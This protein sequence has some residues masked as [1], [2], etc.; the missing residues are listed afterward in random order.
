MADPHPDDLER[1]RRRAYSRH[2][3]EADLRRLAELQQTVTALSTHPG[4][5][6]LPRDADTGIAA[7]TDAGTALPAERTPADAP[8]ADVPPAEAP[9]S[10]FPWLRPAMLG[11]FAGAVVGALVVI[12]LVPALAPSAPAGDDGRPTVPGT[13]ERP[14]LEIFD[15]TPTS[16]DGDHLE[17]ISML[18]DPEGTTPDVRWLADID[19]ARVY[20]A[21][22]EADGTLQICLMVVRANGGG[23]GCTSSDDFVETGVSGEF[24][25]TTVRWG[26]YGT[27]I[28]VPYEPTPAE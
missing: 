2:G 17:M 21:R 6:A 26:P 28:W 3:T 1:L 9:A 14:S 11:A 16:R 23:A 20:A 4:E 18:F 22:G 15:S 7:G 5:P 8:P 25:G 10:R 19:G 24:N 12:A 13:G 27:A